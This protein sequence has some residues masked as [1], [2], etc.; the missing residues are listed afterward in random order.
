[1]TT[2]TLLLSLA[3]HAFVIAG[4]LLLV[5]E[6]V[7]R[8]FRLSMPWL[9][10]VFVC[11]VL[12]SAAVVVPWALVA[13]V[14]L[15]WRKAP[16]GWMVYGGA[17][18]AV[19]VASVS[20]RLRPRKAAALL[21]EQA[22]TL[23][24]AERL[25]APPVG[26]GSR[27]WVART[28]RNDLFRVEVAERQIAIQGLPRELDGLSI[29]HLTDLHFNGTPG[30][31]FFEHAIE[32]AN[33]LR[34]DLFALTGDVLD[35]FA[36]AAWLP[37][38]LRRLEAPLGRYFVLGNHDAYDE[39]AAIRAALCDLGWTDVG[40]R[41]VTVPARGHDLLIAGSE[42]PWLGTDPPLPP[43]TENGHGLRLLLAHTPERFAW[44]RSRAF[45]LVLA[46]HL[47]GGQIDLP[48]FGPVSG[49][50][51]HAGV[52]Q[53]GPTVMHVSRGLGAVF[54]LRWNCPAELTK[55]V[56]RRAERTK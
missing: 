21:A 40:G 36:M 45:H 14:G 38:T 23:D 29:L 10:W 2:G 51:Y 35:R 24:V 1:M 50:R 26:T 46:G 13:D 5:R 33:G 4:H 12:V 44:A 56:L 54:P 42:L 39:P 27:A 7:S 52:F 18:A 43:G 30:L 8:C 6:T 41:A 53:S 15:D 19:L 49:G 34:P 48:L 25:G 28:P 47:H 22:Q 20:T 17:C 32:L 37:T 9:L 11:G 16:L 55:L 3:L 31:P